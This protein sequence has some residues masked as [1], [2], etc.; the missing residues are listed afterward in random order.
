MLAVGWQVSALLLLGVPL[1]AASAE[2][3]LP[4]ASIH[5]QPQSHEFPTLGHRVPVDLSSSSQAVDRIVRDK[6]V[7][8]FNCHY[9][10]KTF[11]EGREPEFRQ[12]SPA[13]HETMTDLYLLQH[14]YRRTD[15]H[16]ARPGDLVTAQKQPESLSES[17]VITHSGVV[18]ETD[19]N[20]VI[21]TIRQKFSPTEP[22]VDVTLEEFI[23]VYAGKH[24]WQCVVWSLR[25]AD[26]TRNP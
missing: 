1:I 5:W 20:G 22:V 16:E 7:A 12:C 19:E 26:V 13:G 11:V 9:Y 25:A 18:L 2:S 6:P 4:V 21:R 8:T 23:S 15:G 3:V 14:G 24:P 17:T 10:T